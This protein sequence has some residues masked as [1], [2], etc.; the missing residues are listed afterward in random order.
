[1]TFS[2][3]AFVGSEKPT[4]QERETSTVRIRM[5]AVERFALR[6]PRGYWFSP[7][8]RRGPGGS[9]SKNSLPVPGHPAQ[10]FQSN[11][12]AD[13]LAGLDFPDSPG[14]FTGRQIITH[15]GCGL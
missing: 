7:T 2:K 10:Q 14:G 13:F 5:Q 15:T 1:M 12:K 4:D 3:V 9:P 8:I 6:P 11:P